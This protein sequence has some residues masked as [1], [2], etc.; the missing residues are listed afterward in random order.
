MEISFI[1]CLNS[2]KQFVPWRTLNFYTSNMLSVSLCKSVQVGHWHRKFHSSKRRNSTRKS[3]IKFPFWWKTRV[4]HATVPNK[5]ANSHNFKIYRFNFSYDYFPLKF[6]RQTSAVGVAVLKRA[7]AIF[8][9][10]ISNWHESD[11]VKVCW[12]AF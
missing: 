8:S 9:Y 4:T 3:C 10:A 5:R 1:I 12:E 6:I 11:C 2:L 7:C